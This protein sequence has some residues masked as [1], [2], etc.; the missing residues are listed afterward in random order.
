MDQL[1]R[2]YKLVHEEYIRS[3][4][5][6]VALK[7]KNKALLEAKED[8]KHEKENYIPLSVHAAS[9]NECKR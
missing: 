9:I 6:I 4:S 7:E 8:F 3:R 5:E 1:Q 2:D